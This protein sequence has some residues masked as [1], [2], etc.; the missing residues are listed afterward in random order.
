[1]NVVTSVS[2]KCLHQITFHLKILC[3]YRDIQ[4]KHFFFVLTGTGFLI[5]FFINCILFVLSAD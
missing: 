3:R 4:H 2:D 5:H 1:M